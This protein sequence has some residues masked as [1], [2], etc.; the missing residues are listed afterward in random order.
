MFN[1]LIEHAHGTTIKT[2]YADSVLAAEA[3][4]SYAKE[5]IPTWRKVYVEADRSGNRVVV[6]VA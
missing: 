4:I 2:G 3:G 5:N 1:A 6:A